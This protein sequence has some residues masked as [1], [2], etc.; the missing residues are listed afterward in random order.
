MKRNLESLQK[1][2]EV[3]TWRDEHYVFMLGVGTSLTIHRC[4]DGSMVRYGVFV[5]DTGKG[6]E[7]VD[8]EV[9]WDRLEE[10]LKR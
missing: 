10:I 2:F 3:R 1:R 8:L 9:E 6:I 5:H 7:I 4:K